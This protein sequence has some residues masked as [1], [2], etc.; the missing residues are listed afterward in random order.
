M[1]CL[2][3]CG[4]KL[5]V[6]SAE[7]TR[8]KAVS[9]GDRGDQGVPTRGGG[10]RQKR[11]RTGLKSP[12]TMS[13]T[14]AAG[15][16]AGRNSMKNKIRQQKVLST[17]ETRRSCLRKPRAKQ[18]RSPGPSSPGLTPCHPSPV[19]AAPRLVSS[20]QPAAE[21]PGGPSC[22][23]TP[24]RPGSLWPAA[25][26]PPASRGRMPGT[27]GRSRARGLAPQ[28]WRGLPAA[29]GSGHTVPPSS[30]LRQEPGQQARGPSKARTPTHSKGG[31]RC[32]S[33]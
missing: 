12:G 22:D 31:G 11:P 24:R 29:P 4:H 30:M 10:R 9:T 21:R 32:V 13:G 8:A 20:H 2:Q 26:L 28:R 3:T 19:W 15:N 14:R 17:E 6:Q 27:V 23:C 5:R 1:P 7:G 33:F 18:P 16:H 25:P